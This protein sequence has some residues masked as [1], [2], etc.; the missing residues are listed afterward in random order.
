MVR[1]VFST[2]VEMMLL[3]EKLIIVGKGARYGQ[4]IFMAGGAGSGKG[5]ASTN[6]LEANKFKTRDVD[7][8]KRIFL[9]VDELKQ[10]YPEIRDLDLRTPDDVAKLHNFVDLLGTKEK[11]LSLLLNDLK[12]GRYPNILFDIT[13]KNPTSVTD[14]AKQLV[15]VGYDP[16]NIHIVWVL[17]DYDLAKIRNQKRS[18]VVPEDILLA[19]HTGASATMSGFIFSGHLDPNLIDGEIYVVLSTEYSTKVAPTSPLRDVA[20]RGAATNIE[21][22]IYLKVKSVGGPVKLDELSKKELQSWIDRYTPKGGV[23]N[24]QIPAKVPNIKGQVGEST[25]EPNTLD[26]EATSTMTHQ[27]FEPHNPTS[28]QQTIHTEEISPELTLVWVDSDPYDKITYYLRGKA[29][30][31]EY[32][33]DAPYF[34]AFLKKD[35]TSLLQQ[36]SDFATTSK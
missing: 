30:A 24:D 14:T 7:E 22:F 6:F 21:D 10:K 20:K 15:D 13:A 32:V 28:N 11:T 34:V 1:S 8:W 12:P 33:H 27:L 31:S 18:R 3:Q 16:R 2:L 26:Q 5:F 9:K 29:V 17:A 35:S 4:V 23:D 36:L 19:T 25:L